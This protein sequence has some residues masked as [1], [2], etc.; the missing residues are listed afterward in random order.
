[1]VEMPSSINNVS[2]L[3]SLDAESKKKKSKSIPISGSGGSVRRPGS[4]IF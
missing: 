1:M 2:T 3:Y 4:F